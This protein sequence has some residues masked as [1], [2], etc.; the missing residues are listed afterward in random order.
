MRQ[1]LY[2]INKFFVSCELSWNWNSISISLATYLKGVTSL[3][4]WASQLV[5][6]NPPANAGKDYLW[7][8]G[9]ED[10]LEEGMAA[11]ANI[12]ASRMPWTHE[13]SVLESMGSQRVAHDWSNLAHMY[14]FFYTFSSFL[15]AKIRN[16]T[17]W[18]DR[19]IKCICNCW[20]YFYSFFF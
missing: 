20:K 5:V 2:C 9:W 15:K 3:F 12:L 17:T 16:G 6:K 10:P 1:G 8:L 19:K 13:P 7:P 4:V 11:H 18:F 14:L